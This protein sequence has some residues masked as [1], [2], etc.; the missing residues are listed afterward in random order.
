MYHEGKCGTKDLGGKQP[1]H[2]RKKRAT[3]IGIG[4]WSSRQLSP[5]GRRV[6]AYEALKTTLELEFVRRAH[7]MSSGFRKIRKWTLWRGRPPPEGGKKLQ[8]QEQ[9]VMWEYQPL[10][11]LQPPLVCVCVCV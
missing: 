10:H 8:I 3:V 6:S 1:P 2:V 11:E 7:G 5:L 4:G 9:P